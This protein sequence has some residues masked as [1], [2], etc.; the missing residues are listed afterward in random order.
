VKNTTKLA[1]KKVT[2]K[3]LDEPTLNDVAGGIT[4]ATCF[5][6]LC[7]GSC[8]ARTCASCEGQASC[9]VVC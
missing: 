5:Q 6:S 9:L 2:L 1:I 4:G 8:M 7:V 3:N